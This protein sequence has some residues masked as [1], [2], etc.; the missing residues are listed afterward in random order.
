M[1]I[2]QSGAHSAEIKEEQHK[3]ISSLQQGSEDVKNRYWVVSG[4]QV[5]EVQTVPE[6]RDFQRAPAN[7]KFLSIWAPWK[8]AH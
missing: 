7:S 5:I 3:T 1:Q 6:D 4:M 2:S 8:P